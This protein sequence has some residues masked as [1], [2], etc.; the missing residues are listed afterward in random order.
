MYF[1]DFYLYFS[2]FGNLSQIKSEVG[3]FLWSQGEGG[4]KGMETGEKESE[5]EK[6]GIEKGEKG[7]EKRE[8]GRLPIPSSP[9][10][11]IFIYYI[12][13]VEKFKNTT[14]KMNGV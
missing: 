14:V 12:L 2:C 10:S 11:A 7:E 5:N 4:R 9:T 13:R 8:K 3:R 6:R 1:N